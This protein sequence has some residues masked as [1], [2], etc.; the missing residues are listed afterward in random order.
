MSEM[1]E[2]MIENAVCE[3][4][5]SLG[6]LSKKWS[7]PGNKGIHDRIFFKRGRTFT[8]EFKAPGKKATKLQRS[9][10]MELYAAGIP[11][12]CIDDIFDGKQYVFKQDMIAERESHI[13]YI[14]PDTKDLETFGF[15]KCGT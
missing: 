2:A 13:R 5:K 12:V 11:C 6:W 7:S 15:K 14:L 8:I 10:A 4:A 3:Y 1:N 9:I